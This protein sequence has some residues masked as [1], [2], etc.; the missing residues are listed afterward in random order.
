MTSFDS[1]KQAI[2]SLNRVE[3]PLGQQQALAKHYQNG[4]VRLLEPI[5]DVDEAVLSVTVLDK[6]SGKS[7]SPVK[8]FKAREMTSEQD[9]QALGLAQFF[10]H[11]I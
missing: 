10:F 11:G 2:L 6:N 9:F 4:N 8:I 1:L 5:A 3:P 7:T